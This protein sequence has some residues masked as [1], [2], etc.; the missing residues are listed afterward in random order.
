M[1]SETGGTTGRTDDGRLKVLLPLPFDAPLDYLPGELKLGPGD[2]VRVPLGGRDVTGVVWDSS[3]HQAAR[4]VAAS[5]LRP[6]IEKIDVPALCDVTRRFV[7]WVANYTLTPAGSVLRMVL[8][9]PAALAPAPVKQLYVNTG[10]PPARLTPGRRQVLD[11][12]V[13]QKPRG[14]REIAEIAMVGE[15]VVRGLVDAGT[16]RPVTVSVDAPFTP[17]DPAVAGPVLTPG[18]ATA[19][20]ALVDAVRAREFAPILLEGVTGSGKTEVYFEAV[21]AALAEDAAQVLVLLPEIALTSQWLERFEARFGAAPVEWHSDLSQAERRRAWRAVARGEA[22]VVVGARSALFLPFCALRLIIVDEEHDPSFKQEDGVIYQARDMAVVRA[23]L[24]ALPV[25]LASATPSLETLYN[26]AAGRY[27]RLHLPD[28]HGDAELPAVTTIDMRRVAPERGRFLAPPLVEALDATFRAGEQALLFLNRRGYAPLT[29]CRTC[30]HRFEC[31][32]CSAWLVEHRYQGRLMCHHCG[33][34]QT[35]PAACPACEAEDTL[36]ACG[37]GVERIA[38]EVAER[39]PDAR[40]LVLSSDMAQSPAR[41][42]AAI[43]S[44]TNHQVDCVIGTQM[45]TKGYHFPRLTLVGVVD[46]DLGLAGGDLRAA[47]RTYQQLAQVAGRAGREALKG[48][49]LLQTYMPEH[50]VMAALI[51]GDREAFIAAEMAAREAQGMPPYGRLAALILSGE[52][53]E[54]VARLARRLGR[55][56][57]RGDGIA[58]LG[59]VTAPMAMVRGRHRWRLLMKARR[60]VPIQKEIRAWLARAGGEKGVRVV[61]DIDPYSFL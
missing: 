7:D 55:T 26:V 17:P 45:V 50:P 21:A 30:G 4:P 28:R 6:V 39:F 15:G 56:A 37:P 1:E 32:N 38:E 47:E 57:P 31:P 27:R 13:D 20:D 2:I 35:P 14:V 52:D 51:S 54:A 5:R 61:V 58:V 40:R 48:R 16:L 36:V 46:A 34:E 33:Y 59:P 49:V 41:L 10:P 44:I 53:G 25:V 8:S 18:Q 24:G 23:R 12:L 22:R 29:L 43:A 19:A 11:V 9:T 3:G 60:D 42:A